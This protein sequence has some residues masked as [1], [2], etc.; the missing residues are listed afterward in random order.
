V[1]GTDCIGSYK[2]N[3]HTIMTTTAPSHQASS[4]SHDTLEKVFFFFIIYL[5]WL[6][7]TLLTGLF[8]EKIVLH[9]VKYLGLMENLRVRRAGFA[10]RRPYEVFLKR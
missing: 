4:G 8:D 10:Y 2:S 7:C 9:Q 5:K 1:I 6:I 3:Y